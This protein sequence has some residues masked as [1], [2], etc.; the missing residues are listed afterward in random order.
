MDFVGVGTDNLNSIQAIE[1]QGVI[2]IS[3]DEGDGYVKLM[4]ADTGRSLEPDELQSLTKPFYTTKK[5]QHGSGMG[6]FLS[7]EIM[8]SF[9]GDIEFSNNNMGGLTVILTFLKQSDMEG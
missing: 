4:V 6:L 5:G 2:K 7:K 1:R 9:G 8:T 3:L